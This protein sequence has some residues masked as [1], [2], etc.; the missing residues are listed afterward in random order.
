MRSTLVAAS[1]GGSGK[2]TTAALYGISAARRPSAQRPGQLK[3]VLMIDA[4]TKSQGLGDWFTLVALGAGT[5]GLD[6]TCVP[7]SHQAGL[8]IPFVQ[9]QIE[10]LGGPTQVDELIIDT[11]GEDP[12]NSRRAAQLCASQH[13]GLTVIPLAPTTAELRRAKATQMVLDGTG[14]AFGFLLTRV[15]EAGKGASRDARTVLEK[16]GFAVLDNEIPN[17]RTVYA[18]CWGTIPEDTGRYANL[19]TELEALEL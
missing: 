9:H 7:W 1:K 8:L 10:Q 14:I 5:Q 16:E 6:I 13:D 19:T 11:G 15:D 17:N 2:T 4:D 3:R 12:E 18:R